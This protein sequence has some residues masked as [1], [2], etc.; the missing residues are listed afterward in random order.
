VSA[1][2]QAR[3]KQAPLKVVPQSMTMTSFSL[4]VHFSSK[5]IL[6]QPTVHL[7]VGKGLERVGREL[8]GKDRPLCLTGPW[9]KTSHGASDETRDNQWALVVRPS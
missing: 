8:N 4:P 6:Q 2:V 3:V 5:F 9:G 7:N 1:D